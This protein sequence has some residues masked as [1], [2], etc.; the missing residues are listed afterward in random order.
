MNESWRAWEEGYIPSNTSLGTKYD[1]ALYRGY[2]DSTFTTLTEQP[3]WLGYQG[4]ILRAEVNDMIE[5][6]LFTT[7][8]MRKYMIKIDSGRLCSSTRCLNFG[9]ICTPWASST[10]KSQKVVCTG[11]KPVMLLRAIVFLPAVASCINGI[12]MH[13]LTFSQY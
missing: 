6:S 8:S 3:D 9:P 7:C 10:P 4:P 11:T 2:T 12:F 5:V 1:K 13:L